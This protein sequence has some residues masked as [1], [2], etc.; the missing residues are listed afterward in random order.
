MIRSSPFDVVRVI[1]VCIII[2]IIRK[3]QASLKN[4]SYLLKYL[5]LLSRNISVFTMRRSLLSTTTGRFVLTYRGCYV[6]SRL[7]CYVTS[8]HLSSIDVMQSN[9]SPGSIRNVGM[10]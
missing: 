10:I 2:I 5:I 3:F 6:T 9:S 1:N 4:L 7:F 8:H